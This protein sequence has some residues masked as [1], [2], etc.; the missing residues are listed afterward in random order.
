MNPQDLA[1]IAREIRKDILRMHR[2]GSGVGSALSAVDILTVLY[3]D[4][5]RIPCLADPGRDRFILSKGHAVAAL[6]ATLARRGFF[7]RERLDQ[8]LADGS[9]LA[10]HPLANALPGIEVA[11]GSLGHGLAVAVGMAF[12]AKEDGL[13][14]RIF[15]LLGCGEMQEG[16]VWEAALQASRL[17]LD[18]LLAIL[19]ANGL[20]GYDRTEEILPCQTLAA[21]FAAF[22]WSAREVNGHDH[23]E[24]TRTFQALP[25]T[26]HQP[27][28]VIA[29]TVKGKGV[30]EMEN[31][32]EWHYCNVPAERLAD[33][34]HRLDQK[35]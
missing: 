14:H 22:G 16:S 29:Y 8:F 24:L 33:W 26:P 35:G 32:L 4:T 11:T 18:K 25:F 7:P 10:A 6:Y 2:R 31:R 17:R 21:K 27:S 19:D 12:A 5:M 20:Q 1:A 30:A 34:L 13:G 28:S 23:Q 3:F 9:S 15:V